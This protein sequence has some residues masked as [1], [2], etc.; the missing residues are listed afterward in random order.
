MGNSIFT[1]RQ[2]EALPFSTQ[3][4]ETITRE[5]GRQCGAVR[6]Q[7]GSVLPHDD[8]QRK[9]TKCS[10]CTGRR[11]RWVFL[12]YEKKKDHT[13]Q[14]PLPKGF[15]RLLSPEVFSTLIPLAWMNVVSNLVLLYLLCPFVFLITDIFLEA[16]LSPKCQTHVSYQ[17]SDSSYPFE[18]SVNMFSVKWKNVWY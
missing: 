10:L 5:G 9:N 14:S 8:L 17:L 1:T 16:S 18:H 12:Y 3:S 11:C 4:R 2:G 15:K 7:S 6:E 13:A